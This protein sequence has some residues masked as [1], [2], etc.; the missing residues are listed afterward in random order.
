MCGIA[1][2]FGKDLIEEKNIKDC[3]KLM[4]RRGPDAFGSFTKMEELVCIAS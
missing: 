1:G 3:R 4:R 2:Y